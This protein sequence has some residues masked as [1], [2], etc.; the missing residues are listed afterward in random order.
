VIFG[1]AAGR[2]SLCCS[3]EFHLKVGAAH[4]IRDHKTG[5][6]KKKKILM[7]YNYDA[8]V[9]EAIFLRTSRR[10]PARHDTFFP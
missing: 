1:D 7:A 5:Q 6:S 9:K 3:L 8:L 4:R 2:V 10:I